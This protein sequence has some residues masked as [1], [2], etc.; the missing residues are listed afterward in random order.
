MP[1]YFF[2]CQTWVF[3]VLILSDHISVVVDTDRVARWYIFKP[4][5]P[6]WVNFGGPWNGKFGTFYGHLEYITA[7]LVI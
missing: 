6:F 2:A 3:L 1:S 7:V 5:I 4:K